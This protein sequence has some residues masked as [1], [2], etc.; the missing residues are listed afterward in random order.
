MRVLVLTN[1]YPPQNLGGFGLCVQRLTEGL[2]ARGYKTLVLSSDQPELGKIGTNP[3]ILRFMQLLGSYDGGVK[4]L[5]DS[6]E[7]YKRKASNQKLLRKA[8][9]G[10]KP[11]ACL[12]GNLDLLGQDLLNTLL[13]L[14]IPTIQ[15]VGFMG[16]PMPL[17]HYPVGKPYKMAFASGEVRRMLVQQGF[18]V[19]NHPV[20]YPPLT[21]NNPCTKKDPEEIRDYLRVGFSGLL[22]QSKGVH[23]LFEAF[24]R[25]QHKGIPAKLSLAGDAF[26]KDYEIQL[27]D[28]ADKV[29]ISKHVDWRGFLGADDLQKFYLDLDV[30]VFPSLHPESFGMV[31][32]EAMA[33]GVVPISSGVGGAY[34]VITHGRNGLLVEPGDSEELSEALA[35]LWR[36]PQRRHRIASQGKQDALRLFSPK[37]SAEKLDKE[38]RELIKS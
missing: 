11:D 12:V 30:L 17:E 16:A 36:D 10:F 15:H 28:Y 14:W 27:R 38:F 13:D 3:R 7:E 9:E 20:I 23:V 5:N 32:A 6:R 25:L 2:E 31:V 35:S 19:R 8:I 24:A 29:D 1:L 34:E 4:Y 33:T 22:M 37:I 18:P 21:T 26:S